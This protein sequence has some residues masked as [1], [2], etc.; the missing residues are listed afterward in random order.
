MK[1]EPGWRQ[2]WV[3]WLNLFLWKSKPPTKAR[4]EPLRGSIATKAASTSGSWV[5]R[6]VFSPLTSACTTRTT[7]PGRILT[8]GPALSDK[9]EATARKPSPVISNGTP[10][11]RTA[12]TLRVLASSTTA[13]IKSSLSGRSL[14]A[15]SIA[16]SRAEDSAGSVMNS[17]GPR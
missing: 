10:S 5:M 14:M 13:D 15:S 17:S 7:A 2:A 8:L 12:T 11:W 4:T 6:Q 9:P 16:S 1:L 3:T